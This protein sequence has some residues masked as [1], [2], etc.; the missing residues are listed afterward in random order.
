MG[1]GYKMKGLPSQMGPW[2]GFLEA[3]SPQNLKEGEQGGR[4]SLCVWS[5]GEPWSLSCQLPRTSVPF[6]R[7]AKGPM[8]TCQSP[9]LK[10]REGS[11]ASSKSKFQ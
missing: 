10:G 2:E 5:R 7:K 9:H 6:G 11:L 8:D 3:A 4:A 1:V